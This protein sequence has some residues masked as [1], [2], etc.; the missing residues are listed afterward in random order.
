MDSCARLTLRITER[1]VPGVDPLTVL[2]L[3]NAPTR[4]PDRQGHDTMTSAHLVRLIN[5]RPFVPFS[6][7]TS[8]GR[9]VEVNDP[10]NV[11]HGGK[12]LAVVLN[13]DLFVIIDLLQVTDLI[14]SS[15][16]SVLVCD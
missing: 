7:P 12:R 11:A 14:E 16:E 8:D 9:R 15:T 13:G 6:L 2:L 3:N 1:S 4:N 10:L 5:T